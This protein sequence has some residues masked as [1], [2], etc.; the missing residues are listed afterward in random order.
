MAAT[1]EPLRIR[2][3][4]A[5]V[6]LS[7]LQD[8]SA[9]DR[10]LARLLR[11]RGRAQEAGFEVQTLRVATNPV[12]AHLDSSQRHAALQV[13]EKLD[14]AATA[15]GVMLSIGPIS[16][17]DQFVEGLAAWASELAQRTHAISYSLTVSSA[18]RGI[19]RGAIRTAAQIISSLSSVDASGIANFRFAAAASVSAGTPFF[20]VAYHE[21]TE[22]LA[23]GVESAGLVQA[24]FSGAPNAEVAEQ[25]LRD[26]LEVQ[27]API[28]GLG[29]E[30]AREEHVRY[31][32][33]DTSPAPGLDRSIG[34]GIEALAGAPFGSAGTLQA[35]AAVT[36]ALKTLSVRMCGY[37]GLMLPVLEDPVLAMRACQHRYG[38]DELLL[39]STVCG[40][41][42][43][44][45]PIPGDVSLQ[46]LERIIGDVATLAVRLRKPLAARL[47]PIPGK[48]AGD[49]VRFADERLTECLVFHLD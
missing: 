37:A 43:D 23:L 41:G 33:I 27:L 46:S 13:L 25:R 6:E 38:I 15:R 44:V 45:I 16:A 17:T 30:L 39:Y 21:G 19:F 26:F 35:C 10:S 9:L 36:A 47:F 31:L 18:E 29:L 28:E 4:T 22:S 2:T 24:A 3:I 48:R 34:A 12:V 49:L 11:A 7:D 1:T 32:G 5:G 8:L 20:P 14:A 40:T 42:L